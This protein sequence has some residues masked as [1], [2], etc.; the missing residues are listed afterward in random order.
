[1]KIKLYTIQHSSV[2]KSLYKKGFYSCS[3]KK[4]IYDESFF[5]SYNW[6]FKE[7]KKR[8]K[9]WNTKFP[10][11]CWLEKPDLR[12]Y[13]YFR[14]S[15]L[16]K[17]EENVLITF[18]IDKKDV[19]FTDYE[20]WH[21]VLNKSY[22]PNGDNFNEKKMS[23]FYKKYEK[24]GKLNNQGIKIM[25]KSWEKCFNL[26]KKTKIQ[27][28]IQKLFQNDIVSLKKFKSYNLVK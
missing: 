23:N 3:N 1:M 10:I 12:S 17:I 21:F 9:K 26:R 19:I 15:R 27:A 20:L 13:R 6:L 4:F 24:N 25:K 16:N 18:F 22:L 8:N 2:L 28:T 11:W 7:S 5:D 14:D